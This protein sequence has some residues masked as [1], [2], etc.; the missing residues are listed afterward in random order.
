MTK[1]FVD[2]NIPLKIKPQAPE[3]LVQSKEGVTHS[4][5]VK[6]F[7]VGN[8]NHGILFWDYIF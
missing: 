3:I 7:K 2:Q 8:R 6:N 5:M 1:F 4:N